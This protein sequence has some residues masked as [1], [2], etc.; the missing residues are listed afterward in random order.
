MDKRLGGCCVYVVTSQT[1]RGL[2][3]VN[4]VFAVT[5]E[6]GIVYV[7]QPEVLHQL[8]DDN[9]TVSLYIV[10]NNTSDDDVQSESLPSRWF[11]VANISVHVRRI[12]TVYNRTSSDQRMFAQA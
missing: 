12:E 11:S 3:N 5:A 6:T 8:I 7:S 2:L 10:I 9:I 4:K 1:S